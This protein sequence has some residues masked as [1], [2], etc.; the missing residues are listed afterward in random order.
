MHPLRIPSSITLAGQGK[1]SILF[2]SPKLVGKTIEN[3]DSNMHD[4]VIRDLL[5]EGATST[6]TNADPNADRRKPFLY[7]CSKP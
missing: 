2:L 6:V 1:E 3:E 7:E 4:V 5:I